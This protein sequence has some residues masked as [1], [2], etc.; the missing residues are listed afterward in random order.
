MGGKQQVPSN[1]VSAQQLRYMR[2]TLKQNMMAFT[3]GRQDCFLIFHAMNFLS[4]NQN[5]SLDC[6]PLKFLASLLPKMHNY[7]ETK[8]NTES[9]P[10][11]EGERN[12]PVSN[13]VK[14]LS[15][16]EEDQFNW[17]WIF[18]KNGIEDGA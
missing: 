13:E 9:S 11:E 1:L 3:H 7:N 16:N 6:P 12:I 18:L 8:Q 10:I 14:F 5:H 17:T 2:T 15:S 4:P